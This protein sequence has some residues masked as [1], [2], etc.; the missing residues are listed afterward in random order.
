MPR[1]PLQQLCGQLTEASIPAQF[2]D[3]STSLAV[4]WTDVEAWARPVPHDSA[5]PGA[6]PEARW[7]HR[8]VGR[9]IEE[10]EMFFGYYPLGRSHGERRGRSRRARAGTPDHG[11]QQRPRPGRRHRPGP[12]S[13]DRRWHQAGR[14]AGRLRLLPPHPR[15]LGQPAARCRRA[16]RARPAPPRPRPPGNPPGRHHLQRMSVL[17]RHPR[18]AAAAGGPAAGRHPRRGRRARPAD[19]RA[20]ALQAR[21]ARRR[22]RRRIPPGT[23]APRPPARSDARSSRPR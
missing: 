3:A 4:D 17:P 14:R 11:L 22:R 16:A 13:H 6:D 15:H 18:P 5:E 20:I 9:A 19:R 2:K 8:N 12:G 10:G 7:G 23:P 21:R 1:Q